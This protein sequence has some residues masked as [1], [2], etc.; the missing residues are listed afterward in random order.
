[1]S[2]S[3]EVWSLSTHGS[4]IADLFSRLSGIQRRI[5]AMTTRL[6]ARS[7]W[8]LF[9]LIVVLVLLVPDRGVLGDG[10]TLFDFNEIPTGRK[11]HRD[12]SIAIESYM[13]SVYGSEITVSRGTIGVSGF[14]AFLMNGRGMSSGVV[15][16]FGAS[17]IDSL[18][19]NWQV[20][21][22]GAGIIIKADGVV[23]YQD[24]LS[25]S[26]RKIGIT[27]HLN[28]LFFD[29][30]V[31]TLEFIGMRNSKIGLDN[32]KVNI[33]RPS[34]SENQSSSSTM[35]IDSVDGFGDAGA[36]H[37]GGYSGGREDGGRRNDG[38][39]ADLSGWEGSQD[40]SWSSQFQTAARVSEPGSWVLLA[41][42]L[43]GGIYFRLF[44]K[45]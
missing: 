21:K 4:G 3:S 24:L 26:E 9:L 5:D 20:F 43:A 37:A 18:A 10:L 2:S 45:A 31:H 29:H 40:V 42:G 38:V 7:C 12:N 13:T 19:L 1:L 11:H 39:D 8:S 17:P 32:L 36:K 16:S 25:K 6:T 34:A 41:I 35:I 22:R 15:I 44:R 30:P 27:G 14:D 33:P 23:I 28:P